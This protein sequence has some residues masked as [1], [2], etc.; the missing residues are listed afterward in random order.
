MENMLGYLL[1]SFPVCHDD[2]KREMY[3][4]DLDFGYIIRDRVD[5]LYCFV[6]SIY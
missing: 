4:G 5:C 1:S 2:K 3:L 6:Y